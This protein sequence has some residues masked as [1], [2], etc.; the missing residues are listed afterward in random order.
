MI[1]F[2]CRIDYKIYND[3]KIYKLIAKHLYHTFIINIYLIKLEK[4]IIA[5]TPI[6]IWICFK[7]W[8]RF[9]HF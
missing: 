7:K 4:F 8:T 5:C 1:N 3:Y 6:F 9:Y 2:S